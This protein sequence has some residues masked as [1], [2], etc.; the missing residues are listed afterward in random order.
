MP[1]DALTLAR[2]VAA[3]PA[4]DRTLL[5][6]YLDAVLER[7]G[8]GDESL[9]RWVRACLERPGPAN[10]GHRRQARKTYLKGLRRRLRLDPKSAVNDGH[11]GTCRRFV[12][13]VATWC[14]VA[15]RLLAEQPVTRA[16][17]WAAEGDGA[18]TLTG[19][20]FARRWSGVSFELPAAVGEV[21]RF[22]FAAGPDLGL[23]EERSV[24]LAPGD[25]VAVH[26]QWGHEVMKIRS[27]GTRLVAANM[28]P[29]W[30]LYPRHGRL[31]WVTTELADLMAEGLVDVSASP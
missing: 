14:R 31:W 22:A 19:R 17:L 26:S 21:A 9:A 3:S 1:S 7:G 12:G 30:I 25:A 2:A 13:P 16:R 6:A 18:E 15:D 20:F 4:P 23:G 10:Y 24:T 27:A 11:W 28:N 8:P 29:D 5:G